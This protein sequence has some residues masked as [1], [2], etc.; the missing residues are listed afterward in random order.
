MIQQLV[1][2]GCSYNEVWAGGPGPTELARSLELSSATSIALGGSNNS[3]ILR[4]TL[5][6]S[7]SNDIKSLYA[8][9]LTFLNRWELPVAEAT[10]DR[11]FEGRWINP[12]SQQWAGVQLIHGW[13]S[14]DTETF[15]NLQFKASAFSEHENLEDLMY[16]CVAVASDLH[17]RGHKVVFWNNCEEIIS[18][19][20]KENPNRFQILKNNPL[21][22]DGLVWTAIPWQHSQGAIPSQYEPGATPPPDHLKHILPED[23]QHLNGY[24]TQW[25]N[26]NKILQ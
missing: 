4:T 3:R 2:N 23:Y 24:L 6:H 22:V 17:R 25:I 20:V 7:Y 8:V 1:V 26:D 13:T 14:E 12:Q 10:A 18:W 19:A 21:F 16:R 15:K 9:G 5:K 11:V